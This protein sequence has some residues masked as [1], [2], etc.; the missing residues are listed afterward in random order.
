[1]NINMM[2]IAGKQYVFIFNNLKFY[3][4]SFLAKTIHFYTF[5]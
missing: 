1:M 2:K 5:N 3:C 4:V